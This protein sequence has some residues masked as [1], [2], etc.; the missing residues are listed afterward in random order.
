MN[1]ITKILYDLILNPIAKK[2]MNQLADFES[3][4]VFGGVYIAYVRAGR[5]PALGA[6]GDNFVIEFML[7]S[8]VRILHSE[9]HQDCTASFGA[10]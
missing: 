9:F 3:F 5:R 10:S 2:T 8:R 1:Q 6:C 7:S 4:T